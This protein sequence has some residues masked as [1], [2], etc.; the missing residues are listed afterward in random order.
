MAAILAAMWFEAGGARPLAHPPGAEA[1]K[2]RPAPA[3]SVAQTRPNLPPAAY[4]GDAVCTKCHAVIA[5]SYGKHP[6][7][8]SMSSTPADVLPGEVG[9]VL[10]AGGL[11]YAIERRDGKVYHRETR[12]SQSGQVMKT[13]EA[14]VRYVLGSGTRGYS[15]LAERGGRLYQSPLSWYSQEKRWDLAPG[16]RRQ[17]LHFNREIPLLCLFCHANRVEMAEGRAPVFHGSS[18]GCERCHGPGELHA[19][20]PSE[21]IKD[22]KGPTIVNPDRLEP[23]ALREDVCAQC[24]LQGFDRE[25]RPGRSLFD[26]RPGLPLD[27]F[28]ALI[29]R[30]FK[31]RFG[32]QADG[33]MD[34]MRRS[35]CYLRSDGRLGCTSCHDPHRVP[36][37]AER[38]VYFRTRCLE[39]HAQKGCSLAAADRLARSP[40]D[41]CVSCHMPRSPTGGI[42]HTART[43]HT[44]PRKAANP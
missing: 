23:V 16:Y 33:H 18:I 24:H 5:E 1:V 36:A 2:D 17:N 13:D 40:A 8:R 42:P 30:L 28:I 22:G 38:V 39:C 12:L 35:V 37:S 4:V 21:S 7:G 29:P 6:M 34:Q 27:E 15:F 19:R 20:E 9:T 10:K 11:E 3:V 41:D 44:I 32:Q 25:S 31:P 14:E 43:D 26:Y